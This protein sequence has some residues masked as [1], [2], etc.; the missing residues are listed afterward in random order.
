[1]FTLSIDSCLF[2]PVV[3]LSVFSSYI[4]KYSDGGICVISLVSM[5]RILIKLLCSIP[6][7]FDNGDGQD[8]GRDQ[9]GSSMDHDVCR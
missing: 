5:S 7:K 3:F 1:M 9:I 4:S 6:P 2:A 8:D